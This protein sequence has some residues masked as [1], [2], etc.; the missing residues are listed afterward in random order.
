MPKASLGTC[1]IRVGERW[2]RWTEGK[3]LVFDDSFEHAVVN[4]TT[5]PR[6]VLLL[7]FWHP[8]FGAMG[9]AAAGA[10]RAAALEAARAAKASAHAF[11]R[12]PPPW[13]E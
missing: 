11:R 13:G 7:R 9:D 6:T 3:C 4:E 5:E 12:W 2:A 1:A 10:R 8:D